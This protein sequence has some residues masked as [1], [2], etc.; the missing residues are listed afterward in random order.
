MTLLLERRG[1]AEVLGYDMLLR[2]DRLDLV[3]EALGADFGLIGGIDL[4]DLPPAM[5]AAGHDPFDVV[6]FSGVLYHMFDPLTG[7]AVVRGLVRDGGICL[8][9]TATVLT[10]RRRCTSTRTGCSPP[11]AGARAASAS[12]PR[13]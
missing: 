11:G 12:S 7:L 4:A 13:A 10:T 2:S 8:V 5:I 3:K 1:A 6:V 9:E